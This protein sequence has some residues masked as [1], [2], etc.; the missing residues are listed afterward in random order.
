MRLSKRCLFSASAL[1]LGSHCPLEKGFNDAWNGVKPCCFSN[2]NCPTQ[3]IS[4]PTHN[5]KKQV[6]TSKKAH[7]T[8]KDTLSHV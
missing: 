8:K 2:K 4:T 5:K 1:D 7:H 3:R 6:N